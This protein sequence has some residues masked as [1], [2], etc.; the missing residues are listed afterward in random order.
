MLAS[1]D[2]SFWAAFK[3]KDHQGTNRVPVKRWRC[4]LLEISTRTL[5]L[6]KEPGLVPPVH[7]L[8]RLPKTSS[9]GK[10]KR[11]CL[12]WKTRFQGISA[13]HLPNTAVTYTWSKLQRLFRLLEATV[14]VLAPPDTEC[15]QISDEAT[16]TLSHSGQNEN[17]EFRC[18]YI[19]A[20]TS[21][22]CLRAMQ[23]SYWC[24]TTFYRHS[25]NI[26]LDFISNVRKMDILR[27][28]LQ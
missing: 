22:F 20:G 10:T 6:P 16:L 23:T 28:F 4:T 25:S 2:I 17:N 26:F 14:P 9:T 19:R 24:L 12:S 7:V 11:T 5:L 21:E 13:A 1:S 3:R 27:R 8:L 15:N 18:L